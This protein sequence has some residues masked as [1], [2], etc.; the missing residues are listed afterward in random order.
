MVVPTDHGYVRIEPQPDGTSQ[1]EIF[2]SPPS[3][4][5]A[6]LARYRGS[7]RVVV[8]QKV[9]LRPSGGS[10]VSSRPVDVTSEA[11]GTVYVLPQ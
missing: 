10:S 3:D 9:Q 4:S 11:D 7:P 6:L 2:G 1:V 5:A 8:D